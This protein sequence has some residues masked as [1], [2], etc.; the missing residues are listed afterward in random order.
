[1]QQSSLPSASALRTIDE[2]GD[3]PNGP[4]RLIRLPGVVGITDAHSAL[5]TALLGTKPARSL[6]IGPGAVATAAWLTRDGFELHHV[7][8]SAAEAM[9]LAMTLEHNELPTVPSTC[10]W[11][12][13]GRRDFALAVVHLPRGRALQRAYLLFAAYHLRAGGRLLFVGAKN[14]GVKTAVKDATRDLGQAGVITRKGGFHVAMSYRSTKPLPPPELKFEAHDLE[15][16]GQKTQLIACAGVFAP[17]RLDS[18]AAA[19]IEGMR[20][21]A[22]DRVLDIG[23]GSGLV[24]LTAARRGAHIS[25]SDVSYRAVASTRRT[26]GANGFTA[27]SILHCPGA[28]A[29]PASSQDIVVSNPPFHRG[30]D[31]SFEVSQLFVAEAA[32]V[33]TPQGQLFL[34]ANR[35]L[36]YRQWLVKHFSTVEIVLENSQFRV[37][38]ARGS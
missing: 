14:E 38:Q 27:Q 35:F 11:T 5:S 3:L 21:A 22:G 31:I 7:T 26:L 8:D 9:S 17:D 23:C 25:A 6:V 29:F 36:D 12:P 37:W 15:V 33:L 2:L 10:E 24:T 28:S 13:L 18:G 19:L 4:I 34:V 20:V 1:M 16:A 30:H 32:R